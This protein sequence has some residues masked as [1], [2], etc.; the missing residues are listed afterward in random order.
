[1]HLFDK[2][3]QANTIEAGFYT[4]TQIGKTLK[5]DVQEDFQPRI[6]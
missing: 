5:M 3:I 2:E 6:F 4:I 1:M